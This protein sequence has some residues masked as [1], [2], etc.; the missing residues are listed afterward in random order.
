MNT[1]TYYIWWGAPGG[2]SG[3]GRDEAF[4]VQGHRPSHHQV[5]RPPLR[6]LPREKIFIEVMTLD[7]QLETF[8]KGPKRR[9]YWT[10]QH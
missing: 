5:E 2:G 8:R 10:C 1:F 6:P 9:I 3:L 7:C 4:A